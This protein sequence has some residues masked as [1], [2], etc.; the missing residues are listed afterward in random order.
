MVIAVM[1]ALG[2]VYKLC[3]LQLLSRKYQTVT[4]VSLRSLYCPSPEILV[5]TSSIEL[6][7]A[8]PESTN[9]NAATAVL[10]AVS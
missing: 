9:W 2:P 4:K 1:E 5:R 7:L 3:R 10:P 6:K 8:D